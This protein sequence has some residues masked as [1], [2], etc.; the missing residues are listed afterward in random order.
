MNSTK[1][2]AMGMAWE[3][4]A[5]RIGDDYWPASEYQRFCR[6]C[7]AMKIRPMDFLDMVREEQEE[8]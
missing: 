4:A 5:D 2:T 8:N 7:H 6:L 1:A 3:I